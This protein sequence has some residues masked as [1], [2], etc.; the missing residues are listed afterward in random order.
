LQTH[1]L[2]YLSLYTRPKEEIRGRRYLPLS[3]LSEEG[4]VW[5]GPITSFDWRH[6]RTARYVRRLP[7]C[8]SM[9]PEPEAEVLSCSRLIEEVEKARQTLENHSQGLTI[10]RVE[11]TDDTIVFVDLEGSQFVR[12][13]HSSIPPRS[14]REALMSSS[15][16]LLP[17]TDALTGRVVESC[18]RKGKLYVDIC[19]FERG[20]KLTSPIWLYIGSGRICKARDP[21]LSFTLV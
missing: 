6:A 11:T 5:P 13:I 7:L 2:L 17:Q 16:R 21:I 9:A 3:S 18:S 1:G 8:T 4:D 10:R 14:P 20:E 19:F 12:T 15:S